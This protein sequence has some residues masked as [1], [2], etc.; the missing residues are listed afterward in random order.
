MKTRIA[1]LNQVTQS[2]PYSESKPLQI[3]DAELD[4]P[5]PGEVLVKILAAGVC[6]SDLSVINGDRPR[7]LPL[8]LGHEAV[9]EVVEVGG[10]SDLKPGQRVAMVFV[11]SCGCC[12]YCDEGRPNLCEPALSAASAGELLNG[13]S[14]IKVN[15]VPVRHHLG[16]SCFSDYAVCDRRSLVAIDSD[17]DP[18]IQA[19]FGCAVLT[20]CGS[21][22]HTAKLQVGESVAIIGLG[23]VGLAA[24][25]GARAAG[26][27][28]IIAVDA[29]PDK[30]AFAMAMGAD[31]FVD[32]RDPE[33]AAQ[34]R[35]L[36]RGGVHVAAEFAGVMPAM[37]LAIDCTRR[38]GRTVT[39]ALPNAND[40][41]P[42]D[43]AA[44]VAQERSLLGS[45]VGSCVP[46]R[47]IPNFIELFKG[48]RLPVDQM[49][50]HR[51]GLEDINVAM[52]RL[53]AGE[54]VRQIVVMG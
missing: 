19:V 9:G 34:I 35:S 49:I 40:R 8:A 28:Q 11:P 33:A 5:K 30:Q 53:A 13:G 6:H 10:Q 39:A 7:D 15:Q 25:L 23:G 36:S 37:Q 41:L 32:A 54:A 12:E 4:S 52:E 24:M 51:I 29:N 22:I 14:R 26:A 31:H 20:G 47:D 42:V 46:S 17:I 45:Y 43:I 21:V 50:T 3:L 48:G 44:L 27:K 18:S 2:R 16:I 38:G 1:Q